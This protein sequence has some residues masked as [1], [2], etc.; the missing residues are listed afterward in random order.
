ML[1]DFSAVIHMLI[2]EDLP[3]LVITVLQDITFQ[4]YTFFNDAWWSFFHIDLHD[5]QQ[6]FAFFIDASVDADETTAI[7]GGLT[8]GLQ[9]PPSKNSHLT[10]VIFSSHFFFIRVDNITTPFLPKLKKGSH[11]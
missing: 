7:H 2:S 10:R 8:L 4:T 1:D 5:D 11:F 3:S 9:L 6:R